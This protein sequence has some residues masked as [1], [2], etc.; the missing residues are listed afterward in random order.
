MCI[1]FLKISLSF[2]LR[3]R[4]KTLLINFVEI[5]YK[6]RQFSLIA[7]LHYIFFHFPYDYRNI[8]VYNIRK[9][10]Q[11]YTRVY[12]NLYTQSLISPG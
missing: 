8:F 3:T 5:I 4:N 9:N 1:I 12:A 10:R 7:K 2:H 6:L 11:K